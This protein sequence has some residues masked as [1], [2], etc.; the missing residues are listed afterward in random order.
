MAVHFN[1]LCNSLHV[2]IILSKLGKRELTFIKLLLCVDH[3]AKS[4]NFQFYIFLRKLCKVVI[5]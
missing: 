2:E 3:D 5:I 4:L 1:I